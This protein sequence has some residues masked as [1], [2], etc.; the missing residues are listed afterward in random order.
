[1]PSLALLSQP[2]IETPGVRYFDPLTGESVDVAIKSGGNPD[3]VPARLVDRRLSVQVRPLRDFDFALSADYNL[4]RSRNAPAVLPSASLAVVA[5]FP[6][7][8]AR[9]P[10]GVLVR[11]DQRPV[12]L[13]EQEEQQLRY[14]INL[15]VPLSL[16]GIGRPDAPR[17]GRVQLS[18][19]HTILLDSRLLL[20][21]GT[22]PID[23]L[24]RDSVGFGSGSKPRHQFDATLGY[25][26]R[27]LGVRLKV[28]RRSASFLDISG[29]EGANVLRF[30]PLTTVDLRAFAEGSRLLRGIGWLK[31][32][33]FSL[34]AV[35]LTNSR[36]RVRDESG[37][38]PLSYQ[39]AYRDPTGRT[40][41]LEFRK[42]F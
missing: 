40:I 31:G 15:T 9:D 42:A 38:T 8:F 25:A 21:A 35:N 30:Q 3:L 18:A 39:P 4:V 20:R 28:E 29:L 13:A 6:E 37:V 7:R 10:G 12:S 19:S 36:E 27:G 41:E 16:L 26:E 5:A 22:E 32:T 24:S 23:L 1:P 14:G 33:R 34:A 11:V 2:P 17:A